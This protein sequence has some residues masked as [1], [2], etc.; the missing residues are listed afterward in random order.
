MAIKYR[1]M[2][3]LKEKTPAVLKAAER[4][5]VVITRRGKPLAI[6]RHVTDAEVEGMTLLESPRVRR[7]LDAAVKD[8]QEG[9]T[10]PLEELVER[11]TLAAR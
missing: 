5:D 6:L 2:K 8:A 7:L 9:R 4:G 11:V 3:D 10:T 1:T